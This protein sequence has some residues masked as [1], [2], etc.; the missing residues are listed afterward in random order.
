MICNTRAQ[1][2]PGTFDRRALRLVQ[3]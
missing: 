2:P 1:S 3:G